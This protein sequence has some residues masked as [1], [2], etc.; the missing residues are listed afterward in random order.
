MIYSALFG[1][2]TLFNKRECAM[3]TEQ[4]E[5]KEEVLIEEDEWLELILL[6]QEE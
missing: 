2:V 5:K 3:P 4:E 1:M 6:L